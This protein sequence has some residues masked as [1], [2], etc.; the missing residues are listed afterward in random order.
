MSENEADWSDPY[1]SFL[2]RCWFKKAS[3]NAKWQGEIE[4]IQ[5]GHT[6]SIESP[7]DLVVILNEWSKRSG[8]PI[9]NADGCCG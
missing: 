9:D 7:E 1:A 6:V 3:D 5:T 8:Y 2:I 4:H